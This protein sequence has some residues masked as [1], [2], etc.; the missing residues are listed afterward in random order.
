M[1]ENSEQY[2]RLADEARARAAREA[3]RR[4]IDALAAQIAADKEAERQAALAVAPSVRSA[5][6]PAFQPDAS[7]FMQGKTKEW[8]ET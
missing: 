2:R 7:F 6:R 5:D 1:A 4:D 8:T 3:E